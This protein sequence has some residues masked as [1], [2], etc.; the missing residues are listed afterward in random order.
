MNL[1]NYEN[2]INEYTNIISLILIQ[3][4]AGKKIHV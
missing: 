3:Y 2:R 1:F 4:A